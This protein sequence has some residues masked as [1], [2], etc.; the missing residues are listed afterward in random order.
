MTQ[1][2]SRFADCVNNNFRFEQTANHDSAFC[3]PRPFISLD[4]ETRSTTD[5]KKT[6]VHKYAEDP[7]T[8]IL[9]A[10]ISVNGAKPVLW[11]DGDPVPEVVVT[12]VKEFWEIRAWNA[13]FERV[14]WAKVACAKYGWPKPELEQFRCTAAEA[15]AMGLPRNL[16]DCSRILAPGTPKDL[17]GYKLMQKM[18]KP[19][20]R[21]PLTWWDTEEMRFRLGQYCVRDVEA[22]LAIAAK[23]RRLT[24][25]EMRVY[26]F[27]QRVND[28]G[29]L[30]DMPLVHA[31]ND[32]VLRAKS[33][34][35]D[36]LSELTDGA[37]T[38]ATQTKRLTEYLQQFD[39]NITSISKPE[40]VRMRKE[41]VL[42][43]DALEAIEIRDEANKSSTAKLDAMLAVANDDG[44]ARGLFLYHG[45]STGRWSSLKVQLQNLKR[46]DP[47]KFE[48]AIPYLMSGDLAA[49]D[50]LFEPVPATVSSLLRGCFISAPGKRF[51]VADYSNIEGRLTA[52]Y[53]NEPKALQ[54]FRDYDAG[55]GADTYK[56][57]YADTFGVPLS[58]VEDAER[59]VGKVI[60]LA[61]GFGGSVGAMCNMAGNDIKKLTR[62]S[63][64]VKAKLTE[65]EWAWAGKLYDPASGLPYDIWTGLK[66]AVLKWREANPNTVAFWYELLEAALD[67]V[68]Y[69]GQ[70]FTAANGRLKLR[71]KHNCLWMVL[72]SGRALCYFQ[73]RLT[74]TKMP[75]HTEERPALRDTVLFWGM[76]Q[77]KAGGKPIWC[78]QPITVPIIV[79]NAV[80][81]TGRDLLS[82]A[83]LRLED[84]G[85]PTVMHA[86]DEDIS[87][88]DVMHGSVK[89]F[90]SIMET[91]PAWAAG[92]PIKAKGWEGPRYRKG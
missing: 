75:W 91:A 51:V 19:R 11:S 17:E 47:D 20:T 56:T 5:L 43:A 36:R 78:E 84:A 55:I 68:R 92:L 74:K 32:A 46:A 59:Q 90:C 86:H 7:N 26:H 21:E 50:L 38:K 10:A 88:V 41:A 34:L 13:Q 63:E 65:D 4:Y 45:A 18:C 72:P 42:D 27:D 23:L 62:I 70:I 9:C 82:T 2:V 89:E 31:M 1:G 71:V 61:C 14:M 37:V 67:A 48:G 33:D 12:A 83:M 52:W 3:M 6:G 44:R 79:E 85:Y 80:Q 39:E 8:E 77:S 73:P 69:P 87:E 58:Q 81:A 29:V 66:G 49:V 76:K 57:T 24:V 35:N 30:I 28:R 40:L 16:D 15:A 22:E 25:E 53:G 64:L 54:A 60:C